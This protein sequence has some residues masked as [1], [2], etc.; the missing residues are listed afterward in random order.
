MLITKLNL[1]NFIWDY[2]NCWFYFLTL[3][4]LTPWFVWISILGSI[5]LV[6]IPATLFQMLNLWELPWLFL[7]IHNLVPLFRMIKRQDRKHSLVLE[8]SNQKFRLSS[9]FQPA[10]CHITYTHVHTHI[11]FLKAK[12]IN[13]CLPFSATC[14][15]KSIFSVFEFLY[16]LYNM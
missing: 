15:H 4:T 11:Y 6:G 1:Y 7:L 16:S 5:T 13:A 3:W 12:P 8:C 10:M 9:I 2:Q 14:V